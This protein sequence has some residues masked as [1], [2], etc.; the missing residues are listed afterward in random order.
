MY[1]IETETSEIEAAIFVGISL[2]INI[3]NTLYVWQR[4]PLKFDTIFLDVR[5]N[6]QNSNWRA[7]V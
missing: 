2:Y 3:K 7:K 1:T 5:I 6:I 4:A